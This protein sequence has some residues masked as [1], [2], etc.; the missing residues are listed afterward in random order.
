MPNTETVL[1]KENSDVLNLSKA[2]SHPRRSAT[3]GALKEIH[4]TPRSTDQTPIMNG[5]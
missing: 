1:N 5:M 3:L 2:Q 4:C